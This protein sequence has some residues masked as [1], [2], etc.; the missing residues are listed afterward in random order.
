MELLAKSDEAILQAVNPLMD[1][2]M[3]GSTEIDYEKHTRDF[4]SRIKSQMS[5][6]ML[7]EIC[8]DYQSRWGIFQKREFVALFRRE[9][10]VAVI[11]KQYCSKTPDEYVAEAVFIEE[12]GRLVID[13]A[14]VF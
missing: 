13:H 7:E 10:S 11:W 14:F 9:T 1:N 4:S 5:P 12:N 3:E 8:K 2:L 6:S